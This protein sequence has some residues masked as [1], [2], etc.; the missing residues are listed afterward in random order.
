MRFALLLLMP[1]LGFQAAPLA[2]AYAPL[3][4]YDG[5]WLA[6]GGPVGQAA[7]D[8]RIANE[9]HQIGIYFGCQQTVDGKTGALIVFV[10]YGAPGHY[11]TQAILN[12]GHATGRGDLEIHGP[13][14]TYSSQATANGV[15]TY[16]RTT[17]HFSDHRHIHYEQA[18]S[19][20]GKT[21]KVLASGDEVHQ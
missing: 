15:A 7:K 2:D 19:T 11:Y 12:E 3:R 21:W 16:H 18:E 6:H 20:D 1:L 5:V 13:D 17:N 10:P 9:C 14:W 8:T 4:L